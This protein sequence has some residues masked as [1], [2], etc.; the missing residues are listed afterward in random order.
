MALE[1]D[2]KMLLVTNNQSGQLELVDV[3]SLP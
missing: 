1:P 3:G 2:G